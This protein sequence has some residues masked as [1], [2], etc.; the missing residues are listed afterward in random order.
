MSVRERL[1]TT[2]RFPRRGRGFWFGVAV[3]LI[4]PFLAL[5]TRLGWRGGEHLPPG[6]FLLAVNHVSFADPMIDTAFVL[7][8]GRLP[9]YL[10]KADLWQMPVARHVLASGGHIPVHRATIAAGDAYRDAVA[11]VTQ[12]ECLVVY[13]ESTY[14]R[15]ADG[16]PMPGKNG[17]AKIALATGVPVVPMAH[18]GNQELWPPGRRWPRLLPRRSVRVLA[19]PPVDLSRFI[20]LPPNKSTLDAATAL[21][22]GAIT[23]LLAELRG[24]QAPAAPA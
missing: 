13:P 9:R 10:A 20:G 17:V 22:M 8:Q 6:G 11:A 7:A 16:W 14:T 19:G 21:I 5:F 3:E 4:W 15:R 18:W 2:L 23:D 1:A 24:E 12:G